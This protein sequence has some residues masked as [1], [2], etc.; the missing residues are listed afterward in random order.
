MK[1]AGE[2]ESAICNHV[3]AHLAAPMIRKSTSGSL[4]IRISEDL[5]R[6]EAS[7][8]P[9]SAFLRSI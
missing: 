4:F 3:V 5:F 2:R 1:I 8:H 7:T 9:A 6:I